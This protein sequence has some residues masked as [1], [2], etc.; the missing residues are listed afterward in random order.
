MKKIILPFLLVALFATDSIARVDA[1][2][3]IEARES[4]QE[5]PTRDT[6]VARSAV[7]PRTQVV[8]SRA[9]VQQNRALQNI[10]ARTATPSV[11][12]SAM[13]PQRAGVSQA[14]TPARAATPSVARAAATTQIES[15]VG[16]AYEQCR[17]A[18]FACMDQFCA[19]KNAAHGRCSCSNRIFDII[20]AQN[21]LMDAAS[22]L[23]EFNEN[24]DVVG[25]TAHQ[26]AAMRQATAGEHALFEDQTASAG[27]LNAIMATI[28]G[29]D[30]TVAGAASVLNPII[31][32]MDTS[33][34]GMSD[35]Q[36]IAQ[37]NG[38]NL[39][40]IVY[41]RCREMVRQQCGDASLQRAVTAY[42]MAIENDCNTLQTQ[43][44][45]AQRSLT[46]NVREADAMLAL[47]RVQNRQNLNALDAT[48]C[49]REV[50]AAILSPE[51]CGPG[52]RRCL[53]NGQFIDINT[54]RPFE[55]VVNF[56]D[57]G[58]LLMWSDGVAATDQRL[59]RNPANRSFVTTFES[60]VKQFAEP[61]LA[62]CT[63][64]R[65]RVWSDFLDHAMLNIRY[66]QL[67]KVE[68]IRDGCL[69]F[70]AACYMGAERSFTASMRGL[71]RDQLTNQPG[72]II[73]TDAVCSQ[74]VAACDRMFNDGSKD[75]ISQFIA[76]RTQEDLTNSCRAIALNCFNRFG[77]QNLENFIHS[78]S[79]LFAPGS[80][81]DWFAFDHLDHYGG[82]LGHGSFIERS[83]VSRCARELRDVASCAPIARTV[84]G[85]FSRISGELRDRD[86]ITV[87][88]Y[89]FV[90]DPEAPVSFS[91]FQSLVERG[92]LISHTG[93]AT[94]IYFRVMNN[95]AMQC[96]VRGGEFTEARFLS[97]E[98]YSHIDSCYTRENPN[99][100]RCVPSF[101]DIVDTSW[102]I[103]LART[104][105]PNAS[106]S[107][108]RCVGNM[109][110][111]DGFCRCNP[112][113]RP[114]GSGD[115]PTDPDCVQ[116]QCPAF[117]RFDIGC[118]VPGG[119]NCIREF[120]RC[121]D[122]R[123]L[124]VNSEATNFPEGRCCL[125]R[126]NRITA[127]GACAY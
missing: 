95:I 38:E 66:A 125:A 88:R 36:M 21:V 9:A 55:G 46:A 89:H 102:G 76:T 107:G 74:Y 32:Q 18:Y 87:T 127:T 54:G 69:D 29:E 83:I 104:C 94:E 51:V 65:E 72:F 79:G 91:I 120:C 28:R 61:V 67:A 6:T 47:A 60:R 121:N 16:L 96:Q 1:P 81:L 122:G 78:S 117:A 56:S 116:V 41:A 99:N 12:R 106:S 101:R 111:A 3:R 7:Q 15:R 112:G 27:L 34:F 71:A 124:F 25:M 37:H 77:G 2:Q 108:I 14:Q 35:A 75:I 63:D 30:A 64:I 31:I 42:L 84:F 103:C 115:N 23:N 22:R 52:F 13:V 57:L 45:E 93:V 123:I 114:R 44:T 19:M 26:A 105:P 4:R 59:A 48:A 70:V 53:D 86:A 11:A 90:T 118:I 100:N 5:T 97:F 50:E 82:G 109:C 43:M 8:Q 17:D 20:S 80:A 98:D 119:N 126:Y 33:A 58:R 39:Y 113:F 110:L 92:N 73:A 49:F 40:R 68:E 24:L 85:G 10:A 62:R